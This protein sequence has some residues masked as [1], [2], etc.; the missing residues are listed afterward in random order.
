MDDKTLH[1]V[2][3]QGNEIDYEIILTFKSEQTGFSYVIYKEFGDSEE[4]FASRYNED[5]EDGGDLIP[6][7]SDEEWDMVEEVLE[8]FLA[9]EDDEE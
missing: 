8:T 3:E 1:V 5:D 9:E 2:D 6:I 7:E 4:V